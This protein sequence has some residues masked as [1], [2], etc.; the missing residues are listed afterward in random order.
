MSIQTTDLTVVHETAPSTASNIVNHWLRVGP[1]QFRFEEDTKVAIFVVNGTQIP[2]LP[3]A[4]LRALLL[5]RDQVAKKD[6]GSRGEEILTAIDRE[7][8]R[9]VIARRRSS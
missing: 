2:R 5:F 8:D 3:E 7:V 6:L 1:E 9:Q 4:M